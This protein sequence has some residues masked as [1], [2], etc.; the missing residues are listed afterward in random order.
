MTTGVTETLLNTDE[1]AQALCKAALDEFKNLS[2]VWHEFQ[3][4][5][6]DRRTGATV[7]VR[8]FGGFGASLLPD[9]HV[10]LAELDKLIEFMEGLPRQ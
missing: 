9:R 2:R 6:D 7:D 4:G 3:P 10:S 8:S 5:A 1:F